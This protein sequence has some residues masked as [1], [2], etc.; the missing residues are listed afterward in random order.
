MINNSI[1]VRF[2]RK[3]SKSELLGLLGFVQNPYFNPNKDVVKLYEYIYRFAPNFSHKNFTKEN[4]YQVIYPGKDFDR[5][6]LNKS[7]NG[8]FTIIRKFIHCIETAS[9]SEEVEL[10]VLKFCTNKLRECFDNQINNKVKKAAQ[11]LGGSKRY[12]YN[13]DIE[14]QLADFL[15]L[16]HSEDRNFEI[17]SKVM[18]QYYWI[19]KL[20]LICEML[21][22]HILTK[23][24]YNFAELDACLE[25]T[26]KNGYTRHPLVHLWYYAATIF[27]DISHRKTILPANYHEFKNLLFQNKNELDQ[28]EK[29][30]LCTYLTRILRHTSFEDQIYYQELFEVYKIEFDKKTTSF[31]SNDFIQPLTAINIVKV[32]LRNNDASWADNFLLEY[33]NWFL[34]GYKYDISLYC[35]ANINFYK[36]NYGVAL[37]HLEKVKHKATFFKFEKRVKFIQIYYETEEIDLLDRRISSFRSFMAKQKEKIDVKTIKPYRNFVNFINEIKKIALLDKEKIKRLKSKITQTSSKQLPE[38]QWLLQKL[39]DI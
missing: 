25:F 13:L 36:S 14:N 4:A 3:L 21:N 23:H 10:S 12:R 9:N 35:Q 30:N 16:T 24:E 38:K 31:S 29:R 11:G 33:E 1:A 34:S 19:S 37:K 22:H 20:S 8:L 39:D 2:L 7:M 26:K 17:L 18:N 28:N 6:K 15:A 32:A 27:R 5:N